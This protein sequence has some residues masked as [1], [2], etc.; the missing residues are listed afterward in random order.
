MPIQ[1]AEPLVTLDEWEPL[2]EALEAGYKSH[3]AVSVAPR[4]A[5]WLVSLSAS[6]A[7]PD[8]A[9]RPHYRTRS[10]P[11]LLP[12]PEQV[13]GHAPSGTRWRPSPRNRFYP[14]SEI[15]KSGNGFGC[16]VTPGRRRIY[17]RL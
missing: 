6:S 15:S 5:R 13:H 4:Q 11:P 12:V 14:R 16:L 8:V 7:G 2:Q 3:G 17:V 1:V 10:R 9:P